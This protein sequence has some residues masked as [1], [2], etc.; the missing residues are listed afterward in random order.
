ML[1]LLIDTHSSEIN[2]CIYKDHRIY[3]KYTEIFA[4]QSSMLIPK[5]V[6]I[7]NKNNLNIS[8]INEVIVV[9]GPGSFTGVRIGVVVAKTISYALNVPIYSISSL[10]L[11]A[12]GNN[13]DDNYSVF[14]ND[15]KGSFIGEFDINNQLVKDYFY[16]S[17]DEFLKYQE[18]HKIIDNSTIYWEKIFEDNYLKKEDCYNIKPL[19]IKKIEVEK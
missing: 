1:S 16:L 15:N 11:K 7:L 9:N 19:Y 12:I 4:N 5:I 8:D 18:S 10:A 14:L 17:K 2:I 13:S 3:D 6:E